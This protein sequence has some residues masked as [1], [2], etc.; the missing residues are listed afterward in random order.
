VGLAF[1][2]VLGVVLVGAEPLVVPAPELG[3]PNVGEPVPAG[4]VGLVVPDVGA[5]E[6][7]DG[8]PDDGA[9]LVGVV[10]W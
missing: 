2:G 1:V 4:G 7:D 9:P 8:E 10:A 3:A 5:G 6:P